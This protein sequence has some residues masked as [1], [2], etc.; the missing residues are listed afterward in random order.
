MSAGNAE[1][2]TGMSARNAEKSTG[3]SARNAENGNMLLLGLGLWMVL[4][5]LLGGLVSVSLLYVERRELLAQADAMAL[6]IADDLSDAAYYQGGPDAD[7]GPSSQEAYEKALRIVPQG[8]EVAQPTGIE[9]GNVVVTL[10]TSPRIALVPDG[11]GT[12]TVRLSA[13]S[14]AYLR[15][16]AAP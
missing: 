6:E 13:T 1:K 12:G 10:S 15:E 11:F 7:L 5:V 4:V 3:I 16:H 8:Y 9:E 2:S 14:R